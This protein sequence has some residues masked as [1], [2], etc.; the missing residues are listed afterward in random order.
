MLPDETF[1]LRFW[2]V[3]GSLACPG[4]ETI[5]Y[6]GN[7][8]CIEVNCGSR[9]LVLDC[10]TGAR[11]LGN[12][13][14]ERD[15]RSLDVL[16]SHTHIDHL[17]GLPFFLPAQNR[18]ASLTLWAGHLEEDYDLRGAIMA[19]MQ[20]PLFPLPLDAL[21]AEITFKEFASGETFSPAPGV[22]VRTAPLNHPEGA[23]GYRISFEG[24]SVC[25]VTDTE[26]VPGRNDESILG[27]VE[28]AN[29]MIYDSTFTE[30]EFADRRGWGHSTWEEGARLAD[31]A[32]VDVFVAFHHDPWH[33][34]DTMDE[35]AGQL[36]KKRP[37]SIVAREGMILVP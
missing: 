3:R 20:P 8:S 21:K 4:P 7:T 14:T 1:W 35:I 17:V 27:L 15:V 23:T 26:H 16:F 9:V 29:L 5:R 11:R 31:L 32:G 12:D 28:N 30:A 22:E 36:E 10:G 34:D 13:L 19:M 33:D 18:Q 25:Y 2:G 6:G 24:R 37:G